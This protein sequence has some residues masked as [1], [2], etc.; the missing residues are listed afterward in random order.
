[1][2]SEVPYRYLFFSITLESA[3]AAAS[4]IARGGAPVRHG[5]TAGAHAQRMRASKMPRYGVRDV[6]RDRCHAVP[7]LDI[8]LHGTEI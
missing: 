6:R 8:H 3:G 1:M 7:K 5:T 2:R 4:S